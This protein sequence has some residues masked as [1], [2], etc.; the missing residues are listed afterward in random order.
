MGT[1]DFGTEE[2]DAW[3][4]MVRTTHLAGREIERTRPPASR[5]EALLAAEVNRYAFRTVMGYGS[6][7]AA[8]VLPAAHVCHRCGSE[9]GPLRVDGAVYTKQG[10]LDRYVCAPLCQGGQD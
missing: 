9:V 7:A 5:G 3:Y 8:A 1:V 4:S 6:G 10:R 2:G